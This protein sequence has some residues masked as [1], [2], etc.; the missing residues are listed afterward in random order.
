MLRHSRIFAK[1]ALFTALFLTFAAAAPAYAQSPSPPAP[2]DNL[3]L[4]HVV[5]LRGGSGGQVAC[6]IHNSEETFPHNPEQAV[7]R[8]IAPV[9][10]GSATC[11]FK[12]LAPGTYA[13]TAFHD[14]NSNDKMD[15][16]FFGM[17][18]EGVGFSN[19][20]KFTF[21]APDFDPC[22][23]DYAGGAKT[24]VVTVVYLGL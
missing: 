2:T 6:A 17:P 21:N 9:H 12:G 18:K 1:L 20:P 7:A 23:F 4:V 3:L 10:D 11:E 22:K 19:N 5:G 14:E 16:Y 24:V 13:V 15:R 8:V